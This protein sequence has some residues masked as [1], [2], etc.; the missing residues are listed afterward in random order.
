MR[1]SL[2]GHERR[3]HATWA[4]PPGH[5]PT[6]CSRRRHVDGHA[7]AHRA[8]RR[9]PV[10]RPA[11]RPGRPGA[12]TRRARAR[13]GARW[14]RRRPLRPTIAPEQRAGLGVERGVGL[15]EQP[16]RRVGGP[17]A[18]PGPPAG[19]DR[20][21]AG[22]PACAGAGR[23]DRGARGRRRRRRRRPRRPA[24]RNG[25]SR[26]R[27]GRRR[28][29]RRGR[30]CPTVAPD[31]RRARAAGRGRA[32]RPRPPVT[33]S[34][35]AQAR[36][37]L[38]LPAPLGPSRT[39]TSPGA[40]VRSTPARAGNRPVRRDGGTEED[41]GGHGRGPCYGWPAAPVSKRGPPAAGRS[42][43]I[44][45]RPGPRSSAHG[46]AAEARWSAGTSARPTTPSAACR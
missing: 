14:P 19:A 32:P 10:L 31:G 11:T 26:P 6:A 13:R 18:R 43:R 28:G 45:A 30:A 21:T 34:R 40:T 17:R 4:S 7:V 44:G 33:G 27:S 23:R 25:R 2:P 3:R 16:Q 24:R 36:S 38:V 29:R 42:T 35:P 37:T 1:R 39:T 5:G 12:A 9:R 22:R 8:R 46:Q 15:V 41:C 20:P